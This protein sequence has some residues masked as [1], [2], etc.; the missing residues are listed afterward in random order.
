MENHQKHIPQL[1]KGQLWKLSHFYI[2]IVELGKRLLEYRMLNDLTETG[3]RPKTS[4]V[5][6]MWRYLQSRGAQLVKAS[7]GA[8]ALDG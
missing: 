8:P 6:T 3:V 5:D 1:A 2:Q 4:T 7:E